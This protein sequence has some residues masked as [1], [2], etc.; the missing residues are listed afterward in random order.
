[1]QDILCSPILR[2]LVLVCHCLEEN[3]FSCLLRLKPSYKHVSWLWIIQILLSPFILI[4]LPLRSVCRKADII[5]VI[6]SNQNNINKCVFKKY[7]SNMRQKKTEF[8]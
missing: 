8:H 5:S 3:C 1:M 6:K 2:F 4:P 7:F